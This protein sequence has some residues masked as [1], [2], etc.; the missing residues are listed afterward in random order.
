MKHCI[1]ASLDACTLRHYCTI[2][3]TLSCRA[4][5]LKLFRIKTLLLDPFRFTLFGFGIGSTFD[6][7]ETILFSIDD[8]KTLCQSSIMSR[9]CTSGCYKGHCRQVHL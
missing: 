5:L 8:S 3:R 7:I 9:K 2:F 6:P 1:H 4:F